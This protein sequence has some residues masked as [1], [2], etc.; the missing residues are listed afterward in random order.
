MIKA[1]VCKNGQMWICGRPEVC[2]SNFV[3]L[4]SIK[5]EKEVACVQKTKYSYTQQL[6]HK[7]MLI[8]PLNRLS[9]RLRL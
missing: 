9:N 7:F 8:L 1:S 6:F 3:P 4:R 2:R 5:K